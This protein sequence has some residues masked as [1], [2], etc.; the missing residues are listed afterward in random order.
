MCR[1]VEAVVP[2]SGPSRLHGDKR[3]HPILRTVV[4]EK[5]EKRLLLAVHAVV[6]SREGPCGQLRR[7]VRRC[8]DRESDRP[9]REN[10]R[11]EWD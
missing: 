3:S 1:H 9:K 10:E 8:D 6:R 4:V 2:G 7:T 5:L 11:N